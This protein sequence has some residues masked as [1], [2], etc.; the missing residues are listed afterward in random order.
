MPRPKRLH[1]DP[2]LL[3]FRRRRGLT[4]EDVAD[5]IGISTEMVRRH[6]AGRSFPSVQNRE[7]YRKIY[8]ASD[9]ALGLILS[10]ATTT[11]RL[12]SNSTTTAP[13]APT[14]LME[15]GRRALGELLNNEGL[16]V[17]TV[18]DWEA[19]AARYALATKTCEPSRLAIDL[20]HDFDELAAALATCRSA[21]SLRRLMRVA[22]QLSGLACLTLIKLGERQAFRRWA[23]TARIAA[24]EVDDPTTSSWVL[25]Q[26]AYGHYYCHDHLEALAVA[27]EAQ[28][29]SM[30]S[31]GGVLAS[32]L[33]A[34][35]YAVQGNGRL[36][37]VA[38][39]RAE[40]TLA[41]LDGDET[42]AVSAFGYNEAQLRFHES[43]ALTHLGD[44][45]QA[46]QTQERALQLVAPEDFMDRVFICLD[47]A[48]CLTESGDISG[49]ASYA[50]E[51]LT[52]ISAG[53]RRGIIAGRA[54]EV[55]GKFSE[56]DQRSLPAACDLR[57]LL[58]DS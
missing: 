14:E 55:L 2:H 46:L 45:K 57:D 22:A 52:A 26:E 18:D 27:Q 41:L 32:A 19:T 3:E 44:T 54:R 4:Q 58:Q 36:T 16:S 6:E 10:D 12:L 13:S 7:K 35:A 42:S 43:N 29:A 17:A 20:A 8:G 31:I 33:E 34:R 49:A 47:R 48:M 28:Q 11:D 56:T 5:R 53:Q 15:A 1:F 51:T 39:I 38:L 50:L 37:H 24:S 30:R 21:R 23:R 9:A 40:E 25:A